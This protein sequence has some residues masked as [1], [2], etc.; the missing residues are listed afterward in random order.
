MSVCSFIMKTTVVVGSYP[1]DVFVFISLCYYNKGNIRWILTLQG[2]PGG[3][4][5]T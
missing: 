4:K 5:H 3:C 1:V 2:S